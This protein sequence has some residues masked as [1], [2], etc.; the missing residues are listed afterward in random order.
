MFSLENILNS[1]DPS[2]SRHTAGV[3]F[4]STAL[5]LTLRLRLHV[6][7]DQATVAFFLS[8]LVF[9]TVTPPPDTMQLRCSHGFIHISH[10]NGPVSGADFHD[11]G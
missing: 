9:T 4:P 11:T 5:L 1:R 7:R 10:L 2:P 6:P 3:G 8:H